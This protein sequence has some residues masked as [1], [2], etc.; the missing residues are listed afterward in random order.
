[1]YYL[2]TIFLS[3]ASA[4][5]AASGAASA[6]ANLHSYVAYSPIKNIITGYI[7]VI[8]TLIVYYMIICTIKEIYDK[9]TKKAIIWIVIC[10][11]ALFPILLFFAACIYYGYLDLYK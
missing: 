9:Y 1:M 8:F 2:N 11:I 3:A 4:A 10:S 7:M 6:A 5:C